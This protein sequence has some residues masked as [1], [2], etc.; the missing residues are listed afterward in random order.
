MNFAGWIV[1]FVSIGTVSLIFFWSIYKV[2]S[3]PGE[4]DHIHGFEKKP[5]DVNSASKKRKDT[6]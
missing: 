3:T 5:P 6:Q 4:T 2:V 1:M